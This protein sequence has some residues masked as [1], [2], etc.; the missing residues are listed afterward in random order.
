[1][2]CSK[3]GIYKYILLATSKPPETKTLKT[4]LHGLS[5]QAKL[6]PAFP[7]R[8]CHVVSVMDPYSHILGFLDRS[9]YFFFQVAPQ[10]HSTRLSGPCNLRRQNSK[11][12]RKLLFVALAPVMDL[13]NDSFK[14]IK[15]NEEML[16]L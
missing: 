15:N 7:D 5:P 12:R 8:G 6:V 11:F 14:R 2:W 4:K 9:R 13:V 1:M 3:Y 16:K 10:L